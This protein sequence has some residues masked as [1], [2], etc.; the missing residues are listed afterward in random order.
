MS[1]KVLD[2]CWN[3]RF[4]TKKRQGFQYFYFSIIDLPTEDLSKADLQ[5]QVL[6]FLPNVT[7]FQKK[8]IQF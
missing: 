5:T 4:F 2:L 7:L 1:I 3:I 6:G 8:L